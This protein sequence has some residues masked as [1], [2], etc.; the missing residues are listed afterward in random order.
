MPAVRNISSD[1]ITVAVVRDLFPPRRYAVCK[2]VSWGMFSWEAD[3]IAI[4]P[5]GIINEVEVKVDIYDFY[6]IYDNLGALSSDQEILGH[7]G[8][9]FFQR[10]L[11]IGGFFEEDT[12]IL[13]IVN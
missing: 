6:D 1:D 7:F 11:A 13:G 8:P 9:K 12:Q 3:I 5:A 10:F 2:N 4:S